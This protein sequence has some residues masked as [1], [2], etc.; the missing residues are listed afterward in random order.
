M[1]G[2]FKGRGVF[3][4]QIRLSFP[5]ILELVPVLLAVAAVAVELRHSRRPVAPGVTL[6]GPFPTFA[7]LA[8]LTSSF[9]AENT[10]FRLVLLLHGTNLFE[11]HEVVIVVV[12]VVVVVFFCECGVTC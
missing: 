4:L 2:N 8:P 9:E 12:V 11:V 5:A 7:L 10:K 3:L 1:V 6:C